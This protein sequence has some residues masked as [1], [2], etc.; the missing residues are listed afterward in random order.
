[1]SAAVFQQR[2]ETVCDLARLAY[3]GAVYPGNLLLGASVFDNTLNVIKGTIGTLMWSMGDIAPDLARATG[4]T[5]FAGSLPPGVY[6][7]GYHFLHCGF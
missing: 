4:Y 2:L 6:A 7:G 3:V 5:S 1:V